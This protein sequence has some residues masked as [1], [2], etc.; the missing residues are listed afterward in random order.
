MLLLYLFYIDSLSISVVNKKIKYNRI[1][2]F[3]PLLEKLFIG[4]SKEL[5]Y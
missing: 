4:T 3:L 5:N 2:I 1:F